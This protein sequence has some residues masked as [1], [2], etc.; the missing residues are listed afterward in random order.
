MFT[1]SRRIAHRP[2]GAARG[3]EGPATLGGSTPAIQM[4]AVI[5]LV[6]FLRAGRMVRGLLLGADSVAA[7][8]SEQVLE[9]VGRFKCADGREQG[10]GEHDRQEGKAAW[11][12]RGEQCCDSP[13]YRSGSVRIRSCEDGA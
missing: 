13:G 4:A 8:Q 11:R 1:V 10:K 2:H 6:W 7:G 5:T 3:W 12:G 9:V